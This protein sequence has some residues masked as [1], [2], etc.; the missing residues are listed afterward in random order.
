[1]AEIFTVSPAFNE[2]D[3]IGGQSR[4]LGMEW[5][6]S[7]SGQQIASI[8]VYIHDDG[9]F[10]ETRAQVWLSGNTT[11]LFDVE[12]GAVGVAGEWYTVPEFVTPIPVTANT[13]YIVNSWIPGTSVGS[14]NFE[15]PGGPI[16]NGSISAH[17]IY[18]NGAPFTDQPNQTNFPTGLFGADILLE[19]AGAQADAGVASGTGVSNAAT[20]A[21]SPSAGVS[22]GT[23]T[24]LAPGITVQ[25]NSGAAAGVGAALQPTVLVERIAEAGIALGVG[26][27]LGAGGS[28]VLSAGVAGG[29]GQAL[30]PTVTEGGA[31][32]PQLYTFGPCEAW[33]VIW[34]RGS[35][36]SIL[37]DPAAAE[38]TGDAVAAASEVLYHLTAQRFGVCQ[39]TL[40]PCRKSCMGNFAWWTWWEYGTYPQP[41]WWN[42]TWYNLACNS[43]PNDSCSC[44]A[45]EETTL[46]GPVVDITEVKLNGEVLV[47]DVDYRLDDYRKLVRLGGLWPFCQDMNLADTENNTWS[48]TAEYGERVPTIGKLAAGELALE[49]V[50]SMLCVECDIPPGV[51]DLSRQG[52]SMTIA[53]MADLFNT[54]F[55]NLRYCDLFIKTAN[56]HHHQARS[57]V[58]DLDGPTDRAVGTW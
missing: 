32:V 3:G 44:T 39:V 55:I 7:D 42:G 57:G 26:G 5:Q 48:V 19:A 22:E 1:M 56:P 46:P 24:A 50:K 58:Y 41:Y 6:T 51:T 12:I 34:P 20:V 29:T 18:I 30:S 38:V 8:R 36:A 43:C 17:S 49:F 31:V 54:G 14:Y 35:C 40:R 11:P 23:G 9:P 52:V 28:I 37:L 53:S 27:A 15:D 47:R 16:V 4:G 2:N 25:S 45:I 10:D 21:V 13:D 33:D